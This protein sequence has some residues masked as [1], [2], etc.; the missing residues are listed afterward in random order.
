MGY[1]IHTCAKMRYK[2]DYGPCD[3]LCP[4][5]RSWVRLGP[6]ALAALDRQRHVALARLPGAQVGPRRAPGRGTGA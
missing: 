4:E 6:E 2:A 5:T 1:Y 3:L